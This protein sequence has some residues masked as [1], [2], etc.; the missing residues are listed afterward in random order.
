MSTNKEKILSE[1]SK[2]LDYI[3]KDELTKDEKDRI[4]HIA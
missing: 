3:L 2:V 4:T 1:A